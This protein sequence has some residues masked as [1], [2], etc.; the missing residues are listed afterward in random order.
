M[1]VEILQTILTVAA[2]LSPILMIG[3][4]LLVMAGRRGRRID[5]HPLCRRCGFDLIGVKGVGEGPGQVTPACPEC[6][7]DVSARRALRFGNRLPGRRLIASGAAASLVGVV[8]L[9]G[10]AYS[11]TRGT[12]WYDIM[13]TWAL[14][15]IIDSSSPAQQRPALAELAQRVSDQ[16]ASGW[17]VRRAVARALAVQ[18]DPAAPWLAEWGDL[19]EAAWH[20]AIVAPAEYRRF[21]ATGVRVKVGPNPFADV[22]A[23]FDS[24]T[25]DI[26]PSVQLQIDRVGTA[27]MIQLKARVIELRYGDQPIHR[28]EDEIPLEA[29]SITLGA[30]TPTI[31]L[32][33]V[34]IAPR[35]GVRVASARLA[36][37]LRGTEVGG[38]ATDQAAIICDRAFSY[39]LTPAEDGRAVTPFEPIE[40]AS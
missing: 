3:G 27:T 19:V 33:P 14:V 4:L 11:L 16:E 35:E 29:E 6:G 22:F 34:E 37:E 39:E 21:L 18:A 17:P 32:G 38:N 13:P 1:P 12:A 10:V 2:L 9:A 26:G 20:G 25:I 36:L 23:P 40:S 28:G 31:A 5:D 8:A 30:G 15:V 7:R 24:S